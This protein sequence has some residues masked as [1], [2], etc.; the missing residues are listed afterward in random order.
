MW[1]ES[2][3]MI[4]GIFYRRLMINEILYRACAKV[5]LCIQTSLG[6]AI[7]F[8]ECFKVYTKATISLK[9]W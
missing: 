7:V 6:L 4:N 5:Y 1:L 8:H 2:L 9:I 3:L